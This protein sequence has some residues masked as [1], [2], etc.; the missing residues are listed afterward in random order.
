VSDPDVMVGGR[1]LEGKAA[2]VTGGG[3]GIGRGI[4]RRLVELGASVVV[5]SRTAADVEET[6]SQLAAL[7]TVEAVACDVSDRAAAKRLVVTTRDRFGS[8]DMLV[9]S[10]GVYDADTPFLDM[11]EE[12][13][14][15]TLSINLDGIFV[16]SQAAARVMVA[17]KAAGRLVFISSINGLASEPNCCDYNTSKAGVHGFARSIAY[18]LAP[19]AITVNVVAPGWVRSPM[20]APYLSED[21][22][23]GR[24]RFNMTGRVGEPE[25]IAGAVAWLVD[26]SSSYVTGTVIPVDGGQAAML[27]MPS[28]VNIE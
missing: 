23:T 9:C 20:S 16:L 10:H 27:P 22:L 14:D 11:T 2:I 5:A 6:R 4:A 13:W 15:R 17:D 3:R 8:L 25:D 28:S 18:D 21:V 19:H 12:H 7:G 24:Q 1:R 26:P